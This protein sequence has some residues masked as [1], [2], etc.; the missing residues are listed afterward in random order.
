M[1]EILNMAENS[2]YNYRVRSYI[3][4]IPQT[5]CTLRDHSKPQLI[6]I[7]INFSGICQY[8]ITVV[9]THT[10]TLPLPESRVVFNLDQFLCYQNAR[11]TICRELEKWPYMTDQALRRNV[12]E[13][14]LRRT[15]AEVM[16]MQEDHNV[17]EVNFRVVMV[18][19]RYI[20]THQRPSI[21]RVIERSMEDGVRM[22][23]T[24]E[25]SIESL[26][27]K[28]LVVSTGACVVCMEEFS[29]ECEVVSMPCEHV[30]HEDCIKKW[31]RTSHYCPVCRFEMPTN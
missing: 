2:T 24:D 5:S 17:L 3:K 21:D 19:E 25:S 30:F 11:E 31:L 23:P 9:S 15:R 10:A 6:H 12:S 29:G 18:E 27:S 20:G 4:V 28:K 16:R 1:A 7:N 13:I 8:S 26:E 14:A 22:V